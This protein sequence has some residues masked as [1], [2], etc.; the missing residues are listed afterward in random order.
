M[1]SRFLPMFVPKLSNW[2]YLP[3]I[4]LLFCDIAG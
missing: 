2:P 4:V 1:V 3:M